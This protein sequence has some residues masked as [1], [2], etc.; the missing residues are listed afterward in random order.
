M[1]GTN[2]KIADFSSEIMKVKMQW[3]RFQ[4]K[5]KKKVNQKFYNLQNS[6]KIEGKEV[7]F[8]INKN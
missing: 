3:N 5:K 7:Y 1:Q 8:Q 6:F 4:I 2:I